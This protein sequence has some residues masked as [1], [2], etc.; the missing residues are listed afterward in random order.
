[1][2]LWQALLRFRLFGIYITKINELLFFLVIFL[3]LLSAWVAAPI[4]LECHSLEGWR[5]AGPAIC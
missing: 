2:I 3:H 4:I 5:F 1:M